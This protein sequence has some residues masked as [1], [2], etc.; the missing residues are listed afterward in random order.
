LGDP[1][2]DCPDVVDACVIERFIAEIDA[3]SLTRHLAKLQRSVTLAWNALV[4][5]H[6]GA[7]LRPVALPEPVCATRF[8]G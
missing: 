7:G 8:L 6:Q 5:L 4:R 1:A 3:A 2:R